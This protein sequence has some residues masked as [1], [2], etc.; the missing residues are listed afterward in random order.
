MQGRWGGVTPFITYDP[1]N[2]QSLIGCAIKCW[3]I[4]DVYLV[5]LMCVA[6]AIIL[7]GL[8]NCLEV[9]VIGF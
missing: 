7:T 9:F 2:N 4:F 1:R 8:L 5:G 3:P 6:H